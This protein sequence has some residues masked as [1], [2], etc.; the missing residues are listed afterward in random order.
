V[1]TA[2]HP[3]WV[4]NRAAQAPRCGRSCRTTPNLKLAGPVLD[5]IGVSPDV[6]E[7]STIRRAISQVDAGPAA[8]LGGRAGRDCYDRTVGRRSIAASP[9]YQ[10]HPM[11]FWPFGTLR[12]K[13]SLWTRP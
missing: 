9:H 8:A 11:I 3:V 13:T 10:G 12:S 4:T 1:A 7:E 6:P 2:P 5:T